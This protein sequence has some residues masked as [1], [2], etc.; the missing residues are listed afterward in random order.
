[1]PPSRF[2][3]LLFDDAHL[4]MQDAVQARL[5]ATKYLDASL[6]PTDR[7]AVFTMSGL[8]QTDF[9]SDRDKI[10]KSLVSILP[11]AVTAV[12]EVTDDDCPPMD[13]IEADDIQNR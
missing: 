13:P 1:M 6:G 5:A 10:H 4:N 11:R 7:A 9:T 2:V 8:F 12:A 3:A